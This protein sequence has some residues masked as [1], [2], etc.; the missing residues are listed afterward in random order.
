M[1]NIDSLVHRFAPSA[2][3][4][5]DGITFTINEGEYVALIGPN[6]CGKTTLAR[7]LNGLLQ[8]TQGR[9][10]VDNLVT[11]DRGNLGEIRRLVG[12]IFQNP[13]NQIVAVTVEEDVA[14]GPANLRLPAGEIR[15]RVRNALDR[16]GLAG[17]ESRHPH[18]LSGG[19][20]QLLALAGVLAMEPRYIVLDEPTSSLDPAARERVLS[21]VRSLNQSGIGIIHIT[22][23]MEE[24]AH[25]HRVV[26]I[27]NGRVAANGLPA[28][29]LSQVEWLRGLRLAPP[30]ITELLWE[31]A[32]KERALNPSAITMEDAIERMVEHMARLRSGETV[33]VDP[34]N[35]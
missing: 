18:S 14:F 25:A 34:V 5:L 28:D 6:G 21:I 8:P 2:P 13:E 19:E 30:R 15:A 32:K 3:R 4:V 23:Q 12:M 33:T 29:I 9:I 35:P 17:F 22:H 20:K 26:V 11:S 16:V 24:V 1:I 27:D 31:L 10:L 7:H